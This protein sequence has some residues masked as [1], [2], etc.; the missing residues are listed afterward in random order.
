MTLYG[1]WG[2][3]SREFIT[4]TGRVLVHDNRSELEFLFP[5]CPIR[6]IP[7]TF[8][9]EQCFPIEQHP[10]MSSTRFPLNRKDFR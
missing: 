8:T 6:E 7:P 5:N 1:L 2:P 3:T 9:S 4:F 10:D